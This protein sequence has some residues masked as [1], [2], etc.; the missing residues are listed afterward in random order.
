MN[1]A[2]LEPAVQV[3]LVPRVRIAGLQ[4]ADTY[5]F[6]VRACGPTGCGDEGLPLRLAAADRPRGPTPPYRVDFEDGVVMVAWSMTDPI[7]SPLLEAY[8]VKAATSEEGPYNVI[9][10]V[11]RSEP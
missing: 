6:T 4:Q 3:T 9:G 1:L 11:H 10:Q 8:V 2:D 7:A 5:E